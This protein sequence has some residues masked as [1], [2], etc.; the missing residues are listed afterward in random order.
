MPRSEDWV[1]PADK[2]DA[3]QKKYQS[4]EKGKEALR[5]YRQSDRG[6]QSQSRYL[7]SNKGRTAHEKYRNSDRGRQAQE[8]AKSTKEEVKEGVQKLLDLVSYREHQ[9]LCIYC[10]KDHEAECQ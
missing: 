9:G 6:K 3:S 5:R 4:S 1:D 10:G 8:R 2:I 7:H